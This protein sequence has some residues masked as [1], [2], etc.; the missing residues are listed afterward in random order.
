MNRRL[1]ALAVLSAVICLVLVGVVV[2]QGRRGTGYPIFQGNVYDNQTPVSGCLVH[3]TS[4]PGDPYDYTDDEGH[5]VITSSTR[6]AGNYC[7][8]A[9]KDSKSACHYS[10]YDGQNPTTLNFDIVQNGYV[11][12]DSK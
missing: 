5:Y 12:P 11:C 8:D 4:Y 1:F 3:L 2:S 6:Q 9:K 10:D 7:L